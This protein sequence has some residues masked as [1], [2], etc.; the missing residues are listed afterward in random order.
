MKKILTHLLLTSWFA[1]ACIAHAEVSEI[2][3]PLGAGGFGFLPL[4]I[5]KTHNLVEKHA[6]L[7]V[8]KSRLIGRTS[9]VRPP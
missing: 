7:Q 1:F 5:M 9:E 3:V 2:R 4:H 8:S 6:D